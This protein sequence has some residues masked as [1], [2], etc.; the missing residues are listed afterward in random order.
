MTIY[1]FITTCSPS[2]LGWLRME[3]DRRIAIIVNEIEYWKQHRL[4]P[5]QYCDYLLALYT[6]GEGK[7]I[8]TKSRKAKRTTLFLE[9]FQIVLLYLSLPF[10]FI[11]IYFTEIHVYLQLVILTLFLLL[12][13]W[14]CFRHI[15]E[16]GIH[17]HTS[18]VVSLF[19][20]LF[21]SLLVCGLL[22]TTQWAASITIALNFSLWILFGY[23]IRLKY[24][25]C[26]GMAGVVF[27]FFYQFL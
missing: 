20:F 16:K 17:F 10:S 13:L 2:A 18:L 27:L 24:L 12:S 1:C 4:L 8:F 21:A 22:F 11:V 6:E 3:D 23:V 26:L 14:L 19:L 25:L 5:E 15:E 7:E 9:R